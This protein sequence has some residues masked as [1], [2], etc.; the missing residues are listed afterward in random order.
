MQTGEVTTMNAL[1]VKTP[2][3]Q[4]IIDDLVSEFGIKKIVFVTIAR[5]FKRSRP[6]DRTPFHPNV[7]GL[8][9][10]LRADI[11]LPP[12]EGQRVYVDPMLLTRRNM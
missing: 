9:N 12:L 6:P 11:G 1:P 10:R 2:T 8:D 4:E 5:L 3:P 7:Y